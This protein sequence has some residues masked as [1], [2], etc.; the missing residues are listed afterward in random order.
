MFMFL[1]EKEQ[2]LG[3]AYGADVFVSPHINS[4]NGA[5]AKGIETYYHLNKSSERPLSSNI[6]ENAIKETG[7]VNRGVKSA[8]FAVI[9]EFQCHHH[10]LKQDL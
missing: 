4:F 7:A 8:N 3:N 1:L 5:S 10:F 6:Q 2:I 9:R